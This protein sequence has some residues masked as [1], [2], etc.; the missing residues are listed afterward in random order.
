LAI[1]FLR[2]I[3]GDIRCAETNE[4]ALSGGRALTRDGMY[5]GRDTLNA[6]ALSV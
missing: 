3:F 4:D 6:V 1:A 5:V 2:N